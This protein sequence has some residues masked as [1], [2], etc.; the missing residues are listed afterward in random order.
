MKY[1]QEEEIILKEAA[2]MALGDADTFTDLSEH[3]DLK[4]DIMRDLREKLHKDLN[5]DPSSQKEPNDSLISDVLARIKSGDLDA[6]LIRNAIDAELKEISII[7]SVDDVRDIQSAAEMNE[8][9]AYT[10][11]LT[12]KRLHD[13]E[14]GISRDTFRVYIDNHLDEQLTQ[15]PS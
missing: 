7:W 15:S 5:S 4:D 8:E 9:S 3:L 6:D 2:K 12:A 13:R 14:Y 1:T 10:V 11:L